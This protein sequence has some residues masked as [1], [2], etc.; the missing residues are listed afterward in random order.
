MKPAA[1][2]Y[3]RPATLDEALALMSDL[4]P[5][6]KPLAGG[7]SLGPMLNM[8]LA[9]PAH[10]VD[11]NDLTEL[12]R[13]RDLGDAIEVG[14]L[15]RHHQLADS[16]L[17]SE[18]CPLLVQCAQS[19]GHYAIRQR[20]TLGGSLAHADPAAQ[21]ALAAITLGATLTLVRRGGHRELA[22][23]D[24]LQAAMTTALLPDELLLSVRFPKFAAREASALRLF[25]RRHGDFGIVSVATCVALD[26]DR[27]SRLRLGVGGVAPVPQRQDSI[28]R[29]FEQQRAN[30]AW[31]T[32]VADAVAQAV[33]PEDDARIPAEY[34][35]ELAHTMVVRAL[36]SALQQL[37]KTR[38]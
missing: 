29:P 36:D 26:G 21:L 9:N 37:K 10:L 8:R 17:L 12:G 38:P 11:L 2:T 18:H 22:A 13:I 1:F 7:Q 24:F 14:A 23:L 19:I 33:Q 20:G 31:V 27:V 15:A 34:R 32:A 4:A 3:H 28:T 5:E 35:R 30:A 6:A 25:S 16:A